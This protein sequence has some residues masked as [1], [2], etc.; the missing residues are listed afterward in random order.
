[1]FQLIKFIGL[2]IRQFLLPNPFESVTDPGR[3]FMWNWIAGI[4]LIPVSYGL[5][6]LVYSSGDD[7]P[8]VG[9]LIFNVT[10]IVLTL[11]LWGILSVVGWII[12]PIA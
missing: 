9:S 3:A 8:V 7:S 6:G 10:Y 12:G 2:I 11:L 4:I 5:T 1:M